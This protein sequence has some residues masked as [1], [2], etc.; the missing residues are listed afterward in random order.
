MTVLA[1]QVLK[2]LS[3][4]NSHTHKNPGRNWKDMHILKIICFDNKE[5]HLDE[6]FVNDRV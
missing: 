5:T 3:L 6:Q 2:L 4:H 1:V